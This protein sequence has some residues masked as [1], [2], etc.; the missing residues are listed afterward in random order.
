MPCGGTRTVAHF[1]V[2]LCWWAA[3]RHPHDPH[4]QGISDAT[5]RSSVCRFVSDALISKADVKRRLCIRQKEGH[6]RHRSLSGIHH[7]RK[8][9]V[10]VADERLVF[11]EGTSFGAPV[12]RWGQP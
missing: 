5:A 2:E 1:I 8:I 11:E 7:S 9:H 12:A 3:G 6:H 4:A 10:V